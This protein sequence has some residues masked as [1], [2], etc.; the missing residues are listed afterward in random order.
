[1]YCS[2]KKN[3]AYSLPLGNV[4]YTDHCNVEALQPY[5]HFYVDEGMG[6][7]MGIRMRMTGYSQRGKVTLKNIS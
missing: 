4:K 3:G 6:M 1:M 5:L 7:R 2:F